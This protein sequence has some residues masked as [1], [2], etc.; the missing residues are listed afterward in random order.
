MDTFDVVKQAKRLVF[1]VFDLE[2]EVKFIMD[3]GSISISGMLQM[4][5]GC[6]VRI[7]VDAGDEETFIKVIAEG[8]AKHEYATRVFTDTLTPELLER[9]FQAAQEEL[10]YQLDMEV[11][12]A[13]RG[14]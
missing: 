1:E 3:A 14:L 5:I 11:K 13:T 4:H 7:R 12:Q 9:Y 6:S 10:T 8:N 2:D